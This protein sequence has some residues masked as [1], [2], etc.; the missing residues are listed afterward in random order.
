[1]S[2]VLGSVKTQFIHPVAENPSVLPSPRVGRFVE[3]VWEKEVIGF[4]G[5]LLDPNLQRLSGSRRDLEL[6]WALGL[7]LHD[8]GARGQLLLMAHVAN[9]EDYE[10]ASAQL[11][12]NTAVER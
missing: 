4:E 11:A 9:F 8:D 5:G 3:P 1:M 7:V 6:N 10:I 2:P 12:V